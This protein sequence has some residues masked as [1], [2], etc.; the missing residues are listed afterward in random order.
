MPGITA[1][2]MMAATPDLAFSAGA[3]CH[4]GHTAPSPVLTAVG[5]APDQAARTIRLGIGRYTSDTDIITAIDQLIAAAL[6]P[7]C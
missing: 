1:E 7:A 2:Q 5:L 3:A 4:T 6:H